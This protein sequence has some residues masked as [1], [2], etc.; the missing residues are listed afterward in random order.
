MSLSARSRSTGAGYNITGSHF[1]TLSGNITANADGNQISSN[2]LPTASFTV[3]VAASDDLVLSGGADDSSNGFGFTKQ[4]AGT[5]TLSQNTFYLTSTSE[6]AQGIVEVNNGGVYNGGFTVDAGTT[7][8]AGGPVTTI[9]GNGGTIVLGDQGVPA[10]INNANVALGSG[11]TFVET[12]DGNSS[13]E[14]DFVRSDRRRDRRDAHRLAAGRRRT[15]GRHGHH[16]HLQ[17]N[18][19]Q[20]HGHV[21]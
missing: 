20:H 17:S 21:Q 8:Y 19:R 4:G 14:L 13:G 7:L 12:Y 16:R 11:T 5:L 9:G 1:I 15:R 2:I 18:R 10:S 6:I 3:T